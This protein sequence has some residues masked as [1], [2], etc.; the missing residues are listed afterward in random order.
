MKITTDNGTAYLNVADHETILDRILKEG[1]G[2]KT[3]LASAKV[4]DSPSNTSATRF[5]SNMV[6][7][8]GGSVLAQDAAGNVWSRIISSSKWH[9]EWQ[10]LA[11]TSQVQMSKI[12]TDDG[13]P[14]NTITSGDI[15]SV[16]LANAPGVKSY[17]S[18]NG[19]SDH[20]SGVVPYRFTAQMTS[21]THG[22]VIGMTDT[23]DAYLRAV[24]GGKWVAEWK[25]V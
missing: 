10:R 5:T 7:A 4:S 25:K 16:V 1:G 20:P 3:G 18:T 13:K 17:A 22:N 19:A 8:T 2:F 24:V 9:T 15:L 12:T 23:G 6:A 21:T 11:A 14:I